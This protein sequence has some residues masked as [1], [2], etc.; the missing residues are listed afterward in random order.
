MRQERTL[1]ER[2][3]VRVG[4]LV[5]GRDGKAKRRRFVEIKG[6]VAVIVPVDK[7]AVYLIREYRPLLRKTVLRLPAGHV[8]RGE[9]AVKAARRELLEEA[10]LEA[11]K[12]TLVKEYDYM[13][14]VRQP[15]LIFRATGLKKT[16]Q[17][18][19]FYEKIDLVRVPRRQVLSVA[20]NRMAEP[21]HA[22]ALLKA[23]L[24]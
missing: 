21:H 23:L 19:D 9:P 18:L 8:R 24:G 22:F 16:K 14:W 2:G 10:G 11:D 15:I 17:E 20:L 4:E 12:L 1:W 5:F 6:P 7:D 3:D 13:E